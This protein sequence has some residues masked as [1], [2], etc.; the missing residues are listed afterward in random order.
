MQ[1]LGSDL[2]CAAFMLV[3][4]PIGCWFCEMPSMTGIVLVE[5]EEGKTLKYMRGMLR[6]TGR[7]TLNATEP[8]RFMFLVGDAKAA[9]ME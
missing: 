8:E 3:E 9:E 6:V 2:D 5:L 1:P 4:N 7:L